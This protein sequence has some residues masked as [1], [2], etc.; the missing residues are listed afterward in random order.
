MT[1]ISP[2]PR[3]TRVNY[4]PANSPFARMLFRNAAIMWSGGRIPDWRLNEYARGQM[5]LMMDTIRVVNDVE[6]D[7]W[8]DSEEVL[9]RL[10]A[11]SRV[12]EDEERLNNQLKEFGLD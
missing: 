10:M 2:C 6:S 12:G 1:T 11:L 7:L 9:D 4:V 8:L 3:V 5:E